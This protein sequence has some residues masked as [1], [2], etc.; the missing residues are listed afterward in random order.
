MS[1]VN[2]PFGLRPSFHPSGEIRPVDATIASAYAN[3]IFQYSPVAYS[4][5]D[6]TLA[7]AGARAIGTFMGVQYTPSSGR[8][9]FSNMWPASQVATQI[10]CFIT[11]DQQIVYDI[12]GAGSI[13]EDMIGDQADWSTNDT[14]AGNTTTGLSNVTIGTPSNSGNAG[15]RVIGLT[16]TPDNDWGDAFTVVQVQISEHQ[17]VADQAAY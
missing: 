11:T 13:T 8:R 17:N 15:L 12:Q 9:Q 5:G 3:N 2:A 1:S 14:N 6:V 7:A 16:Q 10:L 4:A